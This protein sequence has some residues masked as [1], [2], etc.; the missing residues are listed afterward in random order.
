[1]ELVTGTR[2]SQKYASRKDIATIFGY[3]NPN[4][5]LKTFR[6]TADKHPRLYRPYRPYIKNNGMDN[7]YNI[8]CFDFYLSNKDLIEAGTR[9]MKLADVKDELEEVWR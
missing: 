9:S 6:E 3:K 4:A 2:V 1:M 8:V 5:L 7:L